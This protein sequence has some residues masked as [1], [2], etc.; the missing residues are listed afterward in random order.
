MPLFEILFPLDWQH[1]LL[2]IAALGTGNTDILW[3]LRC[4]VL[5][6]LAQG[7]TTRE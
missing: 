6:A 2:T 3:A 5:A 4:I 7:L 1:H